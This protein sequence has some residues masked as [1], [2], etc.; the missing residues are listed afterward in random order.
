MLLHL[1][2]RELAQSNR[3]GSSRKRRDESPMMAFDMIG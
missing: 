1:E 3:Q 2:S